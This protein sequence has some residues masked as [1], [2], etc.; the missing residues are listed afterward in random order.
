MYLKFELAR[1]YSQ[2]DYAWG[3]YSEKKSDANIAAEQCQRS[4]IGSQ[5]SRH[6]AVHNSWTD[7]IGGERALK[8]VG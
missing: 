2:T 1:T 8:G 3:K 7:R 6:T 5:D 4:S